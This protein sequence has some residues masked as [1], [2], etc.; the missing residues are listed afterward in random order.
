MVWHGGTTDGALYS[1]NNLDADVGEISEK[2][3]LQYKCY[4]LSATA[5]K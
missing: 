5:V 2:T 1:V 3:V 4:L